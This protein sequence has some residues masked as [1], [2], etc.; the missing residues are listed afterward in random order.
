MEALFFWIP[1]SA[2]R[3]MAVSTSQTGRGTCGAGLLRPLFLTGAGLTDPVIPDGVPASEPLPRI[4]Q[5]V[6]LTIGNLPFDILYA[7]AVEGLVGITQINFR[8]PAVPPSG[9]VPVQV[10]IGGDTR[11][12]GATL[13]VR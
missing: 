4:A 9:A 10:F 1:S 5:P 8:I 2:P 13:A 11:G 12:Q 3:A 7:G 6:T